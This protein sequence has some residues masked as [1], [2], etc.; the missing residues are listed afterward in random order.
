MNTYYIVSAVLLILSSAVSTMYFRKKYHTISYKMGCQH[1][2]LAI[3]A[4]VYLFIFPAYVNAVFFCLIDALFLY[5]TDEQLL[6][7]HTI[8][9]FWERKYWLG[10]ILIWLIELMIYGIIG[11][12][13]A[14]VLIVRILYTEFA[15][16][17]HYVLQ[18]RGSE[19]ELAD[20]ESIRTAM[21]VVGNYKLKLDGAVCG[22]IILNILQLFLEYFYPHSYIRLYHGLDRTMIAVISVGIVIVLYM[23]PILEWCHISYYEFLNIDGLL[24]NLLL[25]KQADRKSQ[26]PEGYD[27]KILQKTAEKYHVQTTSE[28]IKQQPNI[29]V[30]M[31][32]AF[33]DLRIHGDIITDI[34]IMPYLDG[35]KLNGGRHGNACVS[36]LGGNT[37]YSE[38]EFLTGD[39]ARNYMYC[40][41]SSKVIKPD[42][43]IA[44]VPRHFH[45]L[46]YRTVAMH[47]Y[48]KEN[49][50]RPIV[51]QSLGFDEQYYIDSFKEDIEYVRSFASDRTHYRQII[52]QFENKRTNE[53]LFHFDI[54]MQNH[55]G[56]KAGDISGIKYPV[57]IKGSLGEEYPEMVTYLSLI[58]ESDDAISELIDYFSEY[59]EPVIVLMFGDHQPKCTKGFLESIYKTGESS[60]NESQRLNQFVTPYFIWHN[61]KAEL[62]DEENEMIS[63]NYMGSYLCRIAG[64]EMTGYMKYLTELEKMYPVITKQMILGADGGRI[65]PREIGADKKIGEYDGFMYNHVYEQGMGIEWFY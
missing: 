22:A 12:I 63:L 37:A 53:P 52:A 40:P 13:F 25:E 32:E 20:F 50:R 30:I 36:I 34:P 26:K 9:N 35:Y 27:R 58:R 19:I 57:K 55:G 38:Y 11:N 21:T 39:S 29:I 48:R 31:N 46:G 59:N 60:L 10:I 61:D 15:I 6:T 5:Y 2:L 51:Y 33:S 44:S 24:L 49:W 54:T 42:M 1:L 41:Y 43:H 45:N 3:I 8:M 23:T 62:S 14:S 7:G 47:S 16:A 64:I 4:V 18:S 65:N 17:D 28:I 56:Y